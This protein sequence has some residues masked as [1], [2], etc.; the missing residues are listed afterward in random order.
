MKTSNTYCLCKGP[1]LS[2]FQGGNEYHYWGN[3]SL[4]TTAKQLKRFVYYHARLQ[5]SLG[6]RNGVEGFTTSP[7]RNC[8]SLGMID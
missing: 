1:C 4:F 2:E 7:E 6:T 5:G 3:C 8:H